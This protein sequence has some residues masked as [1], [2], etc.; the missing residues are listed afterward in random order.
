MNMPVKSYE[1]HES[2]DM[3]IRWKQF[4]GKSELTPGLYCREHGNL[5]K[6]L[7]LDLAKELIQYGVQ[8]EN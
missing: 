2:C 7:T 4:K 1:L 8:E 5:V 6:W 3:I